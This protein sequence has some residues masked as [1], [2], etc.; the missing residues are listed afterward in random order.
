MA[1]DSATH[2]MRMDLQGR[3]RNT[4]VAALDAFLPVFEAIVNSIHSIEDRFGMDDAASQ[5]R[6]QVHV[7]RV[8]QL[9]VPGMAGRPPVEPVESFTV[10]DNGLGFTDPNLESFETADSTAKIVRGGKGIG[11][12]TWLVVFE[13][14][15]I[16]S[17]FRG[18]D[19]DLRRRSFT[20]SPTET[21]ISGFSD[22]AIDSDEKVETR[23]RLVGVRRRYEEPL[24]RGLEVFAERVFEHCFNYFVVGNCPRVTVVEHRADGT[25]ELVVNE[26]IQELD[27]SQLESLRVGE[28]DLDLRHV[29]QRYATGRK[30][31]G[32][33][34]ANDRVVS[35]FPLAEVS[36]LGAEPIRGEEGESLI[37]HAFVAGAALD[38]AADAT[39]TY[40]VLPDGEPIQEASGL[41]DLKTLRDEVGRV[42]NERL[43]E[44]LEAERKANLEKVERHIRT[45]QPEYARLL[46]QKP[47][48]LARIK[49]TDNTRLIDEAL[50]RVKQEWELEIR[51][52]QSAVEQKLV[53]STTDVDELAEQLY[54]VVSET[55]LAGQDDLVRYVVKRRAVLQLLHKL[56]SRQEAALEEHIHR[57]VFPLKRTNGEI[58]YED[59]NLWLVDDTLSFYEFIS[60]ELPLAQSSAAP[61]DSMER[62]DILAFKT[63]DPFQHV[64]LVEFKRPDRKDSENPVA[65]LARY[66]RRLRDGGS[67]D[68]NGV[69]L[70]GIGMNIRIDG[71][72]IVTLNP[73][74]ESVLSDGPGEMKRV[75]GEWRWYGA[76][77]NLNMNVEVLDFRAFVSRAQQRNQAFFKALSLK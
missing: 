28:H 62:P 49:W 71:Y 58:D 24:R 48:E 27:I 2:Q 52:E 53:E 7:H 43:K 4:K 63:G 12:L 72:A 5:G 8:Q 50:Y 39:R 44:V 20:F 54:R 56:I 19:G 69:T 29:Q 1:T 32:H 51:Q 15:E 26:R 41:L 31:L 18:D 47:E 34:L 16:E 76:L 23:V 33:L 3:L 14:A 38:S 9:Q 57:I 66:A 21:G 61:S 55:N 37:H 73:K 11:R 22:E 30:H 68:A 74:M 77:G 67:M 70:P 45:Q 46:E 13:R 17:R 35:S 6:I 60:S 75:E 40:F 10:V 42:V 25:T 64:S 59:H 65:Q 36:D